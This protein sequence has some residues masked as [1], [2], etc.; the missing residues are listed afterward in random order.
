M[1]AD[2]QMTPMV[3]IS[4]ISMYAITLFM[5]KAGMNKINTKSLNALAKNALNNPFLV[6]KKPVKMIMY[7]LMMG[8]TDE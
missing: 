4:L 8:F 3:L 7:I 2:K 1:K 6:M 5:I